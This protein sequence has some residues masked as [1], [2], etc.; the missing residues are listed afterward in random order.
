MLGRPVLR[1]GMELTPASVRLAARPEIVSGCPS[2]NCGW[3]GKRRL[4]VSGWANFLVT[5]R[6]FSAILDD[7]EACLKVKPVK[8][9]RDRLL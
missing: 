9:G 1:V 8:A 7:G 4:I 3:I 2:P 6:K 5:D